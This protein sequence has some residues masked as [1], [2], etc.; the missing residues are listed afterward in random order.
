MKRPVEIEL[1]YCTRVPWRKSSHNPRST[2]PVGHWVK[3]TKAQAVQE[4]IAKVLCL[5]FAMIL[6]FWFLH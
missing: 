2:F 3:C 6:T 1:P 5:V 4:D